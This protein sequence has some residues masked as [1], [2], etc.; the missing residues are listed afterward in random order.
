MAGIPTESP[1]VLR[2]SPGSSHNRL[3]SA[4]DYLEALLSGYPP[5]G[6]LDASNKYHAE[7][8]GNRSPRPERRRLRSPWGQDSSGMAIWASELGAYIAPGPREE[9]VLRRLLPHSGGGVRCEKAS[10][11]K[12]VCGNE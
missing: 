2:E 10:T 11:A 8:K 4:E 5:V 7:E 3:T 6:L 9:Y 12:S 1:L